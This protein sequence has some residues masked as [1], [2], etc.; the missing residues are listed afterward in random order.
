MHHTIDSD[1]Y[2]AH[3]VFDFPRDGEA[4]FVRYVSA[5]PNGMIVMAA[6]HGPNALTHL[7]NQAKAVLNHLGSWKV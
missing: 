4:D 5:I 2:P 1:S 3:Q 6:T 7:G